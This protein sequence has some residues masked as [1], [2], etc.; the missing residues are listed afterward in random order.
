MKL[1]KIFA[2]AV[3]AAVLVSCSSERFVPEGEHLL[4]GVSVTSADPTVSTSGLSEYVVQRPN[5]KW[6]SLFK[7]PLGVYLMQG[8]D[9]TRWINKTL[10]KIGE[11]PVIFD[12]V[13]AANSAQNMRLAVEGMG[14]LGAQVAVKQ[15]ERKPKKLHVAYEV[16]PGV[17]TYVRELHD[18]FP[19]SAMK[20][21]YE[22]NA[23]ESYLHTGI[24]FDL[25][26]LG[27]E[28]SRI[29]SMYQNEGY[30]KFNR[31][32]VH[33]LADTTQALGTAALTLQ[34]LPYS[35]ANSKETTAHRK[36]RIGNVRYNDEAYKSFR[37]SVLERANMLKEG[38]L[39]KDQNVTATYNRLASLANV[40]SSVVHFNQRGSTD[41]IDATIQVNTTKTHSLEFSPEATNT[42][43]DLGAAVSVT[44]QNRNIFHGGETFLLKGRAAYEAIKGLEGY[45]G[46]NGYQEYSIE[47]TLKFPS[48]KFPFIDRFKTQIQN[49]STEVSLMYDLQDRPEFSRHVLTAALRY[50]WYKYN[51]HMQHRL[52][53]F[54]LNYIFLPW[55]SDK[56]R[57]DYLDDATSRNAILRYNY[58]NIFIMKWG[59]TYQYSSRPMVKGTNIARSTSYDIRCSIETAGNL[60]RAISAISNNK[61]HSDGY[62]HFLGNAYAQYIKGDVEY[63][64]THRIDDR[65]SIAFRGYLGIAYPYGNSDVLPYD[66]RF[67]SGGANSVRGWSVRGLGPGSFKGTDGRIDFIRQT[68]DLKLD[69]SVEFRSH[70][71]WKFEGAIF[72]DAGNIWTLRDY[73]EQPGGQ[74]RFAT[75]W[76]E[77]AAA[78]GIGLRLNFNYFILRLDGGMKA[79]NPAEDDE[80][81]H[82]PIIHPRF[83]RDFTLHFAVGLPF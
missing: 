49:A 40:N 32:F 9:T 13:Q 82:Y 37:R 6:F 36:F 59:Y 45:S 57:S 55:I 20:A 34:I 16:T 58:E 74:F 10:R 52:D 51:R 66:K 19:D 39:Y 2:I 7:V 79:I 44:Y 42:A 24:P 77:I 56:F 78:Y 53:L 76:K 48:F 71:F 11:E 46:K 50:R 63:S 73:A 21:I 23:G 1:R 8:N 65:N 68:G 29:V 38:E 62:L 67:F 72:I 27:Q 12:S 75:F 81:G 83:K 43:G 22:R 3:T 47:T 33:F 64:R 15:E 28:R 30:Y 41:T 25:N 31:N 54:D 18:E 14:Y 70:L 5:S 17:R 80:G 69:L 4:T 26:I 60:L 61:I 35:E